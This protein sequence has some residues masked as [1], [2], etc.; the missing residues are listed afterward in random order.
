MIQQS[1][2]G[3]VM[4]HGGRRGRYGVCVHYLPSLHGWLVQASL[5]GRRDKGFLLTGVNRAGQLGS[6]LLGAPR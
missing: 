6:G 3:P 1:G 5:Q 4:P 2:Q